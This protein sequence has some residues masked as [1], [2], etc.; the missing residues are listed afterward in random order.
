MKNYFQC[1]LRH[2]NTTTSGWIEERGARIGAKV[3]LE[4][5]SGVFWDVVAVYGPALPEN[6]LREH[7]RMNR[8]SLPSVER[9]I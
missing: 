2:E 4:R 7:Q 5:K 6:M 8:G 9:M 3:E 1:T